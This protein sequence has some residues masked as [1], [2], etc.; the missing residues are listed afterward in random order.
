MSAASV[1]FSTVI[2]DDADLADAGI[3]ALKQKGVITLKG[4]TD[5]GEVDPRLDMRST[6]M[7]VVTKYASCSFGTDLCPGW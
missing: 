7:L 6:H 3:W 5:G 1:I 4:D 2:Y